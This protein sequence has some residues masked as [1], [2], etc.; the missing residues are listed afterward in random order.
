LSEINCDDV[1]HEL[2]HFIDGELDAARSAHLAGHLSECGSCLDRAGFQQRV[3]EIV[4]T[5]C[6]GAEVTPGFLLERVRIRIQA[7]RR[8]PKDGSPGSPP[9]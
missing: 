2:E 9:G 5:K 3:K 7:E 4:R 1:L 6:G 8:S